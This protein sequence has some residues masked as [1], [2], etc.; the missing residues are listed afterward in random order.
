MLVLLV[1]EALVVA[2]VWQELDLQPIMAI[3]V[4]MNVVAVAMVVLLLVE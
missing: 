4:A 3:C 2:V 1:K